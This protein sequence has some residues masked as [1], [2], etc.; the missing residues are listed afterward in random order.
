MTGFAELF[1]QADVVGRVHAIDDRGRE[2]GHGSDDAVQPASMAKVFLLAAL[3]DRVAA[4]TLAFGDPV[5]VAAGARTPGSTG[6]SLMRDEAVLSVH[7]VAV[8]MV[9]VS[10]NH[11][12]DVLLEVVKP[13][14]VTAALVRRGLTRC[15]L[16]CRA[17]DVLDAVR[18]GNL[19]LLAPETSAWAATARELTSLLHQLWQ[20]EGPT[21]EVVRRILKQ[22]VISR[23][24]P[25][26]AD[27]DVEIGSKSGTLLMHRGETGVVELAD[28]RRVAVTVAVQT[29][30]GGY[31]QPLA[32]RAVAAAAR[33]AVDLLT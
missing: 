7:D 23:F 31:D 5:R 22:Q 11:A 30:D 26:F 15:R 2:V 8:S 3:A 10:D 14:D 28:G 27:L 24:A 29:A 18:D 16:E 1:D 32:D 33:H 21:A 19:A 12:T 25:G 6:L 9:S 4:G 17:V 13:A 20:D